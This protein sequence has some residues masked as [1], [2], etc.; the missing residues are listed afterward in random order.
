[1]FASCESIRASLYLNT[2]GHGPIFSPD[3]S[4]CK[5]AHQFHF[6]AES[7]ICLSVVLK[8]SSATALAL[9]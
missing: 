7:G 8:P 1:M 2:I 4:F 5:A 3:Y 9:Y 6:V